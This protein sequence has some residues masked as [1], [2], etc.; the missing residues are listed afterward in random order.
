MKTN[1]FWALSVPDEEMF[2]FSMGI[3]KYLIKVVTESFSVKKMY[4]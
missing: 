4:F 3:T 2:C 1:L